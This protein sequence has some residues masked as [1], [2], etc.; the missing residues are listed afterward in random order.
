MKAKIRIFQI[1]IC[2]LMV[3]SLVACSVSQ[4]FKYESDSA[5]RALLDKPVSYPATSFIVVSD[6]HTYDPSLG[7]EGKAFENYLSADRKL[8][9]ESV[10][11]LEA[12][13]GLIN[14]ENASFV[15]IP[16]DLTKDGELTSHQLV[17]QHL[18]QLEASGKKIY[19]IPGN[20]DINNGWSYSYMGDNQQRVLN[21][22]PEEFVQIYGEF[23]Y[24]EAL[25]RDPNSL[26]YVAEPQPGLWLLA[27]DSC[28]YKENVENQEPITGGKFSPQTLQWIE[29]M[30]SKAASEKKPVIAMMHHGVVEHYVGQAKNYPEYLIDDFPAISKLFA[31]YNVRLVFTGHYH[32]Q[33]ITEK[34]WS[35]GN[36]FLFDVETGSLVTYSCPYRVVNI[37][38]SQKCAI[39]TVRI[40]SIKS[41][42][43]GFQ[44]YARG[45]LEQGITGIATKAIMGYKVDRAEAEKL[46]K[47]VA[48]AFEAHYA[49]DEK[50]PAGQEAIQE[51]G[52]SL[53]AWVV[54]QFRKNLVYGLWHDLPPPDNNVT[55]DLKTGNWQ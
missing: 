25:S 16:G 5:L 29:E 47:Q 41:H 31:E 27:L 28:R 23:G 32:A 34:S 6:L 4:E 55:I 8:L 11:L 51:S 1:A 39:R 7:T 54:V 45:Y 53:P 3:L 36:K 9:K 22:S 30:L 24:N 18:K 38:N 43:Q 14:S 52:L 19:V 15:L 37:D 33:D 10:E 13:I 50:L 40:Q 46:A 12:A 35:E 17:A 26:S 48:Q 44:E 20:H 49:G 2:A 42:P 21:I